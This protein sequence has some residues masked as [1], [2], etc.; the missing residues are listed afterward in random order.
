VQEVFDLVSGMM[1][2]TYQTEVPVIAAING[3]ARRDG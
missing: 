2:M 1:F 3:S